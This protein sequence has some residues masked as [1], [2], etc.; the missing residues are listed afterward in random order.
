MMMLEEISRVCENV[1]VQMYPFNQVV[2][3]RK[4]KT[5]DSL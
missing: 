5:V 4:R 3:S 1:M 2:E